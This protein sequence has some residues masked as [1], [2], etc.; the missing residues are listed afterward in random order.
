MKTIFTLLGYLFLYTAS[1]LSSS[2][3][4][5]W[6]GWRGDTKQGVIEA[7]RGP[8]EWSETEGMKWTANIRGRGNSSPVVHENKVYLTT[9]YVHDEAIQQQQI[10]SMAHKV[11]LLLTVLFGLA[12][13]MRSSSQSKAEFGANA[14][15]GASL[16]S[17]GF[18]EIFG[19]T[20]LDY[21]RCVIRTWLG[22]S[23]TFT[24]CLLV[25]VWRLKSESLWL[26]ILGLIGIAFGV[27]IV[28]YVPS[29]D[30]AFRQGL[31][32]P[33]AGLVLTFAILPISLG[34]ICLWNFFSG[35]S[36]RKQQKGWFHIVV[37]AGLVAWGIGVVVEV[38]FVPLPQQMRIVDHFNVKPFD[39]LPKLL[40]VCAPVLMFY[41]WLVYLWASTA[42][43]KTIDVETPNQQEP[44]SLLKNVLTFLTIGAILSLSLIPLW[45][46]IQ[47]SP[48]LTYHLSSSA[49]AWLKRL[50]KISYMIPVIAAI[51][52]IVACRVLAVR[53]PNGITWGARICAGFLA[54]VVFFERNFVAKNMV[55]TRAILC[56]D[57]N[58]GDI[59]WTTRTI[60][61]TEGPLHRDNSAATPTP[62]V[63]ND[64]VFADFS[65]GVAC[66][67]TDG[68]LLWTNREVIFD[69]PYGLGSSPV[70]RDGILVLANLMPEEGYVVGLDCES[71]EQRWRYEIE[72]VPRNVSGCSRTPFVAEIRG[73]MTVV[74]WDYSG[75]LGLDLATGEKLWNS[76]IG[77]GKGDM[78][79]GIVCDDELVYCFGANLMLALDRAK[80][81][82]SDDLVW[83]VSGKGP[84][85]ASAILVGDYLMY[86]TDSGIANCLDSQSGEKI[87]KKRFPGSYYASPVAVGEF[88]YFC[89]QVGA[90]TVVRAA[91]KFEVVQTNDHGERTYASFA[92]T[93]HGMIIRTDSRLFC[94]D[95]PE[96]VVEASETNF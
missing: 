50:G 31:F 79:S 5:D 81:G 18:L 23:L 43:Q 65:L 17:I 30:H 58:N 27:F 29:K 34:L 42:Q 88:V 48:Y 37:A 7:T 72:E 2:S 75:V 76:P 67:S 32:A 91:R 93:D 20:A 70:V 69:S 80:I 35:R 64:K 44:D 28:L 45:F 71:G 16:F 74:L 73:R 51:F 94:V 49:A 26:M 95:C 90:T 62:F 63:C 87:W 66:C 4:D 96:P 12:V 47:W 1:L 84:N 14:V 56:V 54:L 36:G 46:V 86:V 89:N 21:D 52:G 60:S 40:L 41:G 85:I 38:A 55:L 53:F 8:M 13:V 19:E 25:A 61:G 92:L 83:E 57:A 3:A 24:L 10:W 39:I 78:V 6:S 15:V 82:Q 77:G 68:E 33:N 59:A 22:S 9:S 11:L